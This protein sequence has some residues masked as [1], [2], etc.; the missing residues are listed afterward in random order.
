MWKIKIK[1]ELKVGIRICC[2]YDRKSSW[3][4]YLVEI[5]AEDT[6][7][8]SVSPTG[9]DAFW[10]SPSYS[11]ADGLSEYQARVK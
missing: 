11:Y 3:T 5:V 10:R 8:L 7:S 6:S 9:T 2:I 4:P 1:L